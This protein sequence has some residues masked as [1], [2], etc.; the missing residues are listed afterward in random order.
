[1]RLANPSIA[2]EA[3]RGRLF[4]W[5]PVCLSIGI[6][7]YFFI[8]FEPL[9]GLVKILIG[10]NIA[11]FVLAFFDRQTTSAILIRAFAFILLGFLLAIL[12]TYTVAEPVL[13]WRYYGPIEGTIVA[14]DR[15]NANRPRITLA[16]PDLGK[17]SKPRTPSYVRVS[18][19]SD[20]GLEHLQPGARVRTLGSIAPPSGPVEPGGFDFQQYAW[21]KRLGAVGYSRKPVELVAP[22]NLNSYA[23]RLFD[24]RM[25]IAGHVRG[26]IDGQTGA[27][28]AAIITGDRSAI[29]PAM[30]DDLRASNLAHLLAISGLHM[31][32]LVGFIFALVRY[33]LALM[34]YIALHWQ[35]KKLGAVLA[36]IAGFAYLQIS[37][38]AVA[39]ERAFIMV[40]VMLVGVLLDRPAITLRAVALAATILLVIR[41][42]SLMQA[43]FQMSFAA[44]TAL[45][46]SFEFLKHQR[47]WQALQFGRGWF[48][49]PF[50]ALF[51]SSLIAGAATAPFA[52]FHFNQFAQFGLIANL[53]SVPVMGLL[54]MPSAVLAGLLAPFGLEALPFW[55][56][57]KGVEWILAVAH[58]VA[59]MEGS[60]RPV[61]KGSNMVL[62]LL[63]FGAVVFILWRGRARLL[64][65]AICLTAFGLW[66]NTPRPDVL[67]SDTGRLIG[68]LQNQKRALNRE[69]GSGFAARVWLENDGDKVAQVLAAGRY[70]NFTDAM[71]VS[72]GTAKLGYLWSK[73]TLQ[74][75]LDTYCHDTDILISPNWKQP[76]SG[77]CIHISQSYL[78]YNGS[79]S[80]TLNKNGPEIKTARQI[81]GARIW[82]AW[83]L[84][85]SP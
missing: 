32:L 26:Q 50:M 1:M 33:G 74:A 6:G 14:I 61:P 18:L 77:G 13:G 22:S 11:L 44:T 17:I 19:H 58:F 78:R 49:Q 57:G 83:W 46:A 15:S 7:L 75:E 36:L 10:V 16:A 43:G 51:I 45:V 81:T 82:N 62:P 29:D 69:R 41:P 25:R 8:R 42:E 2:L 73:K 9:A 71:T 66:A 70:A 27:F 40:S 37:G 53:G 28:S 63:G 30:L 64:G 68:V 72:V 79:V 47:H 23:L 56:M 38:A 21:F 80:I 34:P 20:Q 48:L 52:A 65:P 67:I 24:L 59:S 55:I 12:R 5:L 4:L 60:A 54:V 39:T 85:K 35:T 31:G 84:R 3:Q 76:V